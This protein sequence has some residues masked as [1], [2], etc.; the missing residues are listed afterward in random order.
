MHL[1]TVTMF[2]CAAMSLIAGAGLIAESQPVV[3]APAF[4][5]TIAFMK[6]AQYFNKQPD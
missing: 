1:I 4:G 5:F 3:A 2:I 6:A